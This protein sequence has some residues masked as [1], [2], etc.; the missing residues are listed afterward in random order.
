MNVVMLMPNSIN[1]NL[2]LY[3]YNK[4][5]WNKNRIAVALV[6]VVKAFKK[7]IQ[8][9]RTNNESHSHCVSGA[10]GASVSPRKLSV[11]CFQLCLGKKMGKQEEPNPFWGF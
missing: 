8:P 9:V 11:N 5:G 4:D 6:L 7:R 2:I 10:R 3:V 1:T